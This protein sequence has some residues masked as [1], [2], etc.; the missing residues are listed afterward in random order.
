MFLS[1]AEQGRVNKYSRRCN[2]SSSWT[3]CKSVYHLI[4]LIHGREADR[5]RG[6]EREAAGHLLVKG[7]QE[8]GKIN[9]VSH[10]NPKLNIDIRLHLVV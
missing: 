9:Y 10:P 6:E 8:M 3:S 1:D 7:R 5:K 2:E 4:T